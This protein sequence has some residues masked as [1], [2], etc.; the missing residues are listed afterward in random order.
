MPS[1]DILCQIYRIHAYMESYTPTCLDLRSSLINLII[2]YI[3]SI[4]YFISLSSFL[5][6]TCLPPRTVWYQN[7]LSTKEL[8]QNPT[9]DRAVVNQAQSREP[10]R[11]YQGQ[12]SV[13]AALRSL[14][15]ILDPQGPWSA[16]RGRVGLAS[17]Y[18]PRARPLCARASAAPRGSPVWSLA[19][20]ISAGRQ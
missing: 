7:P 20:P 6:F 3:Y 10:S 18:A 15:A 13:T 4:R 16:T 14:T 11:D 5:P 19:L 17:P 12:V 1:Q 2:L 9:Y 8:L